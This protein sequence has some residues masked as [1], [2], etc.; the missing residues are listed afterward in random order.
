MSNY[1]IDFEWVRSDVRQDAQDAFELVFDTPVSIRPNTPEG[2]TLI[3]AA[4][5]LAGSERR[6]GWIRCTGCKPL[7]SYCP[8]FPSL[9]LRFARILKPQELLQFVNRFGPLTNAGKDPARGERV[10]ALL[11]HAAQMARLLGAYQSEQSDVISGML[12]VN[13]ISF[14]AGGDV[15]E[16][17]VRLVFDATTRRPRL[18]VRPRNLLNYLWL[19]LAQSLSGQTKFRQCQHCGKGFEV[20][21]GADRRSDAKFCSNACQKTHNSRKRTLAG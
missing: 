13:G 3:S 16:V 10:D 6:A 2:E 15:A 18:Q 19:V 4:P 1:L 20:G 9:H 12:G 7:C 5:H 21:A 17:E 11:A 8:D 14:D